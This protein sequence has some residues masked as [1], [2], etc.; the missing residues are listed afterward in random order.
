MLKEKLPKIQNNKGYINNDV[1]VI[2]KLGT[3]ICISLY[4]ICVIII[5]RLNKVE[6]LYINISNMSISNNILNGIIAQIQ[7]LLTVF[8]VISP[9]KYN[10]LIAII[11][12]LIQTMG[13]FMSIF[14]H[15]E[16]NTLPGI[17][18]S[19]ITIITIT[20]INQYGK[21]LSRQIARVTKQREEIQQLYD[22]DIASGKQ[23]E[24]Q[25]EQI[26]DY[27]RTIKENEEMLHHMYFYDSLTGIPNR[28]MIIN[29]IDYLIELSASDIEGF[30]LVYLDIDD[31][32][33]INDTM[34]HRVG[35][36]ILQQIVQRW[37]KILHKDDLLGRLGGDEFVIIIRRAMSNNDVFSYIEEFRRALS[38]GI[39]YEAKE[40]FITAS[41]GVTV[42]P[43]DGYDTTEILQKAEIALY[44]SKDSGKNRI[45]FFKQEMQGETLQRVLLENG[46]LTAVKNDE[47][48]VV[49]QPLYNCIDKT[50][51][52]FEALIRWRY[53]ELGLI[54]P[55][56][57]IPIAEETGAIIDIGR[58]II[59]TVLRKFIEYE[60]KFNSKHVV[61]VNISVVQML[62]P[63]FCDMI[64]ETLEET[65]FD[66]N[67]LELEI[68]ESVFIAY[69]DH[70]IEVINNL[71]SL[72][73]RIALDDFG[74]GFASLSYLQV[75][76]IN[77][78]KIDKTFIDRITEQY[79][80]NHIIGN[81][82]S[83][84]H[85]LGFEVVAEGVEQEM[86][87]QYLKSQDCDYIQGYLLS[88]PLEEEQVVQL[89][90][91]A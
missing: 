58:W 33:K 12:C 44:K 72:G 54:S 35:D 55:G 65:G 53:P 37:K 17:I 73:I 78:L 68:T 81:I 15:K 30:T 3:I 19:L 26:S 6:G 48:F 70:I 21:K 22:K 24:L 43:Q 62:E 60:D 50:L 10:Y 41:F 27:D 69:P 16:M 71:K 11:L 47:L 42:Y 77:V 87:L 83:L 59:S 13:I 5:S 76:P 31:F 18:V 56:K 2:Y 1:K 28:K 61:S 34:G 25:N 57:F 8:I 79:E 67:Y 29:Q 36:L 23:L 63:S 82:I 45:Y 4:L 52:G 86:Q 32:K 38:E 64:K 74:T 49:F 20:I 75:L 9:I 40:F 85:Q 89:L 66:A 7:V 88:K 84:A 14:I 51:R 39:I 46:L 80:R 90:A 91:T